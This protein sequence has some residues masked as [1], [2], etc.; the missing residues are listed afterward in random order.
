MIHHFSD[1]KDLLEAIIGLDRNVLHVHLGI[2]LFLF[3][4][5]CFPGPGRYRKAFVWLAIIEFVNEFSDAMMALDARRQPDWPD[6]LADIINTL[7]WPAV[8]CLW[9]MWE[10]RRRRP[11]KDMGDSAT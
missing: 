7:F 10:R 2:A 4:A 8:W 6:A 9:Q 5:W 11:V 3:L 1:F